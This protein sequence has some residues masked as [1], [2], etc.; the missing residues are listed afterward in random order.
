MRRRHL[1]I[2]IGFLVQFLFTSTSESSAQVL[3]GGGGS[4]GG[5][6]VDPTTCQVGEAVTAISSD[7][8]VTCDTVAGDQG[9]VGPAGPSNLRV[10][11]L[12]NELPLTS[13]ATFDTRNGHAVLDFDPDTDEFAQF[14]AALPSTYGGGGLTV[15]VRFT[16]TSATS[17]SVV[18]T[19][20]IERL[21]DEAI[22]IDV[23]SFS[24]AVTGTFT[25]PSTS[26]FVQ[27]ATISLTDGAQ[28]DSLAAGEMFR[29]RLSRD[30][31]N[32]ADTATGDL[33]F[34]YATIEETP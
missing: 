12:S 24:A 26:G 13:P 23:D 31:D 4:G 20:A 22:D 30:A 33:E 6:G 5:T 8:L 11:A 28:I 7:G 27:Y 21:N 25:A 3:I 29:I 15:I 9:P 19:A 10:T 32:V 16:M 1:L 18:L 34:L 17:G 14:R 2:T